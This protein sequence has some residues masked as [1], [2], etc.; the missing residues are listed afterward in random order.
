MKTQW[1]LGFGTLNSGLLPWAG[2]QTVGLDR[3]LYQASIS[4][5]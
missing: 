4:K 3:Y 2:V 5:N 1:K